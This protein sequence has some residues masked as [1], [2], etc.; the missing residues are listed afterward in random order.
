LEKILQTREFVVDN[1]EIVAVAL[2]EYQ[3]G[4]ADFSDYLIASY[5]RYSDCSHTVTFDKTA[6]NAKFLNLL[7]GK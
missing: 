3:K 5:N 7:S 6:S 4:V 1:A 2:D